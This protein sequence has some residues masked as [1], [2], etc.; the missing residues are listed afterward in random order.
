MY[1]LIGSWLYLWDVNGNLIS[2]V[3][4]LSVYFLFKIINLQ[5]K[6]YLEEMKHKELCQNEEY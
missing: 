1:L 3:A 5:F 4:L 2:K 6:L